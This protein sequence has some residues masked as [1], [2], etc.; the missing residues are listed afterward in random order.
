MPLFGAK[1]AKAPAV[2]ACLFQGYLGAGL[3]HA[4][5]AAMKNCGSVAFDR[6]A[7]HADKMDI[8]L[9]ADQVTFSIA[10]L[11]NSPS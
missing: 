11:I 4:D 7:G 8:V 1:P 3:L 2:K 9:G 10:S 6:A 5:R